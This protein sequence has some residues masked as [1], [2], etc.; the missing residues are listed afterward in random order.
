MFQFKKP[1]SSRGVPHARKFHLC[2]D[3]SRDTQ[4]SRALIMQLPCVIAEL[5]IHHG[6][7]MDGRSF[8]QNQWNFLLIH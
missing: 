7:V 1:K 5:A 6:V 4:S 2:T 8:G 3:V